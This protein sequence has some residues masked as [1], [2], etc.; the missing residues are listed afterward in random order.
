[1]G[2]IIGHLECF[3]SNKPVYRGW[4]FPNSKT[5]TAF[6]EAIRRRG[7][8]VNRRVGMS[9]SLSKRISTS[10]PFLN[11]FGLVWEIR[12]YR[13]ARDV[14]PIFRA[15]GAKYPHQR[16]VIFPRGCQF[17]LVES[18]QELRVVRSGQILRVPYLVLHEV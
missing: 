4:N 7:G 6:I 14:S 17:V 8:F 10:Q 3:R 9:A 5:R 12:R 11:R 15:I 18:P 16:E 13:L 2:R 1:M